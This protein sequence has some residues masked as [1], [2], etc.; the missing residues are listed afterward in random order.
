MGP[1][2][3]TAQSGGS[4]AGVNRHRRCLHLGTYRMTSQ[5]RSR[6]G[7]RLAWLAVAGMAL[8][9]LMVPT[10]SLAADPKTEITICHGTGSQGN[11]Y[12]VNSPA[13]NSSGAFAGE[14]AAG[15]NDH[16]G[17][18]W[19]PGAASWG[20]IIPPYEYPPADFTYPGLNWTAAGQAIYN[21]DCN[22]VQ[23]TATPTNPPPTATPTDTPPTATPT[24]TPPTAT[25]TDAPPTATP[26]GGVG[27]ATGTPAGSV[28][29][30]TSDPTLPTTS[31]ADL[32]GGPLND[33]WRVILLG[34][35]AVLAVALLLT[36]ASAVVRKDDASR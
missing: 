8:A 32:T 33:G 21:N 34:L 22:A 24:D 31:T 27:G 1:S 18:L 5:T 9:A 20:D 15:H 17:P 28:G 12:V 2:A 36:P 25:P 7:R 13:I 29:G 4:L 10:S 11:P 35:A 23:A 26:T 19:T 6:F 16:T 14:L 30:A 3:A